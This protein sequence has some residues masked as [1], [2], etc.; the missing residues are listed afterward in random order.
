MLGL[1]CAGCA[2]PEPTPAQLAAQHRAMV[3]IA[4]VATWN[5]AVEPGS[6]YWINIADV[7]GHDV[8]SRNYCPTRVQVPAGH[9]ELGFL[10]SLRFGTLLLPKVK[11]SYSG[12][13]LAGH[14]YQARPASVK[15]CKMQ[16]R[17][18]SQQVSGPQQ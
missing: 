13:F 4:D 11:S 9:A 10:C 6:G 15:P 14:V 3:Y 18:M 8:C 2:T 16:I 1:L 7:D 12:N 17:D 5:I